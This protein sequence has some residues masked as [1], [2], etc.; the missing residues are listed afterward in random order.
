MDECDKIWLEKVYA[1]LREQGHS[2][3]EIDAM[4]WEKAFDSYCT[5]HGLIGWGNTL[6]R[7]MEVLKSR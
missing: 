7:T 4:P 2:D 3:E 5:W 6:R 1:D